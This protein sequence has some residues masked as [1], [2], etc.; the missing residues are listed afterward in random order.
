MIIYFQAAFNKNV[1]EKGSPEKKKVQTRI[2]ATFN[3]GLQ[4]SFSVNTA[5]VFQGN[6]E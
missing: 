5:Y 6:S 3:E 4:T 1:R 2:V